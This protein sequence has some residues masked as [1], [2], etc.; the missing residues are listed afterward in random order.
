VATHPI[1]LS[2]RVIDSGV[3]DE[4]LNRVDGDIWELT[5]NVAI[6]ESFSHC[7]TVNTGDGLMCFDASGAQSGTK[8]VESIRTWSSAPISHLVYTHGHLDHVGGSGAFLADATSRGTRRP[9]V[10]SHEAV[11]PRFERYNDMS[12]FNNLINRR[13]FG[14][15]RA[16]Q[17]LGVGG[18]AGELVPPAGG[19]GGAVGAAGGAAISRFLPE[20]AL[21]PDQTFR[22]SLSMSVGDLAVEMY[23]D[24]GETDDHLWAWFPEKKWIVTGDFIIWNFPNAGN[25]QKVQRYAAEWARALRRMVAM[26]PELLLPAHG[27][28]IVGKERIAMVLGDIA[29]ALES[30]VTQVIQMMNDGATLDTIV[31]TVKVPDSV[32]AKPYM[33]PLYD[34]PEFVVRGIWRMYGGWWDGAASRLKPSPDAVLGAEIASLAGGADVLMARAKGLAED[35]DMRLA[36]HLADFAGWAAPDDAAVHARRAELYELRRKQEL[37]LMSKGIFRAAARESEAVVK[38]QQ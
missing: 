3:V 11:L 36:C 29:S 27:L 4:R 24:R 19:A 31:H 8:V 38:R 5:D 7:V 23:H 2:T 26:G 6:V 30:L 13:Q 1:E 20:N 28:P 25:P 32:L 21:A 14:G 33:R 35:G 34:E 17:G 37:S 12:D 10:V 16:D 22:E 18:G 9:T 15:I